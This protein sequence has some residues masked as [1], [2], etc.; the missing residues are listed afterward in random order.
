[1][2]DSLTNEVQPDFGNPGNSI[3]QKLP[4]TGDENA[5][6]ATF[7]GFSI[8]AAALVAGKKRKKDDKEQEQN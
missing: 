5:L 3:G 7:A 1:M 6:G 4:A 8:L 2:S